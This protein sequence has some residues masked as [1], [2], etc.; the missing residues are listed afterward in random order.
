MGRLIL[1]PFGFTLA[2]L[3]RTG[4]DVSIPPADMTRTLVVVSVVVATMLI[5]VSRVTSWPRAGLA[6]TGFL[7]LLTPEGGSTAM[8][9]LVAVGALV[10]VM[11]ERVGRPVLADGRLVMALNVVSA[12]A[13]ISSVGLGVAQGRFPLTS[14]TPPAAQCAPGIEAGPNFYVFLLDSYARVDTLSRVMDYDGEPFLEDLERQGFWVD[15]A[16]RSNYAETEWV[17]SSMLNMTPA[18]EVPAVA[19]ELDRNRRLQIPAVRDLINQ[20]RAA[21]ILHCAGYIVTATNLPLTQVMLAGADR[22]L[23]DGRI[24]QY[25]LRL[26]QET[27]LATLSSIIAPGWLDE[28]QRDRTDE[29]IATAAD[30]AETRPSR[31]FTWIHVLSPHMPAVWAGES[32][33]PPITPSTSRS[34]YGDT[35]DGQGVSPE[36][37][38]RQYTGQLDHL[39]RTVLES[40][41]RITAADPEAVIIVFSD[42]GSGT[43]FDPDRP[44]ATDLA[45]RFGNLFAIRTPGQYD[46][47]MSPVTPLNILGPLFN[48]YL[49]SDVPRQ[50]DQAWMGPLTYDGKMI[51][52][53]VDPYAGQ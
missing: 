51:F 33:A 21:D 22:F 2:Y 27:R 46:I 43:R 49:G 50:T 44:E 24:N 28:Q 40:V 1:F 37:Y 8:L 34:Y 14:S 18:Q 17:V 42:H 11:L 19:R 7:L 47:Y 45:E 6:T 39:Q 31:R 32:P 36:A 41:G 10:V 53:P 48:A 4:A 12:L 52:T 29:A 38:A 20:S 3:V 25:E 23:D 5:L 35:P 15:R 16:S 13:L 30:I 9:A 26:L